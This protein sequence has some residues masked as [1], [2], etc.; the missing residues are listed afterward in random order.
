MRS[1]RQTWLLVASIALVSASTASQALAEILV[2][3]SSGPA[4]Q[5]FRAGTLLPD[6]RP[7]RLVSGDAL[8]LLSDTGTWSWRGPGDFPGAASAR[9]APVIVAPD[10]RR[11]RVGAVRSVGGAASTRPNIWMVDVGQPGPVCVLG[12]SPPLLWRVDAETAGT[13]ILSGP[14]GSMAEV[15][16]AEGQAVANWPLAVAIVDGGAYRLSGAGATAPVNITVR[17][18]DAPPASAPAA[19]M[20]LIE[21]GC[22]TQ[23]DLLVLQMEPREE[24]AGS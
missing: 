20:A 23:T 3:R 2:L 24:P 19:G 14:G 16:W 21:R 17:A 8:E 9:A 13:T 10:R 15:K 5:R 4:A 6:A 22:Q 12:V 18:L 11:T 7:I 1:T